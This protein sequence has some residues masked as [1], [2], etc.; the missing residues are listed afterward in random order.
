MARTVTADMTITLN[1]TDS[2]P[3]YTLSV[4]GDATILGETATLYPTAS[5]S[6][7]GVL[8]LAASTPQTL[9]LTSL[10][11]PRGTE[12]FATVVTLYV[13][14][15]TT[16]AGYAVTIGNAASNAFTGPLS[17]TT[18]TYTIPP[19]SR[20]VWENNGTAWTVDGTHKSLKFDPGSNPV[21]VRVVILG[22]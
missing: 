13:Y 17:G 11:G 10:T 7:S 18:P 14:N 15:T 19:G 2:V 1:A 16:T 9:D 12:T 22:S 21:S 4:G 3:D 20:L 6:W 5:R 8:T